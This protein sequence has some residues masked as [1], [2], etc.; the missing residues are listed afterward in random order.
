MSAYESG[1]ESES[2]SESEN[3]SGADSQ[4]E[5]ES[6]DQQSNTSKAS[7]K[8]EKS[9]SR[10]RST[11]KSEDERDLTTESGKKRLR[12]QIEDVARHAENEDSNEEI[13]KKYKK[14]NFANE[15]TL[16]NDSLPKTSKNLTDLSQETIEPINK[17]IFSKL[18]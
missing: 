10:S 12:D 8:S 9:K 17:S 5:S 4:T 15:N 1:A 7:S 13:R 16:S 3:E 2:F 6:E 14:E 11:S 18:C